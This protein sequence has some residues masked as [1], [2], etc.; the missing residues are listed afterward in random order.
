MFSDDYCLTREVLNGTKTITR[1]LLKLPKTCNGKEVY[2]FSVCTNDIGIQW[3]NL[4]DRNDIIVGNWKPKYEVG[5]IVAIAQPYKDIVA[6]LPMYSGIIL[7]KNG[8][9]Y[10]EFK[11]GWNN[12]MF[13]ET[14][15]MPHHIRITNVKIEHL[16]DISD[17]DILREGVR[18]VYDSH[19]HY[20]VYKY[21]S[22]G[23]IFYNLRDA[24]ASLFDKVY[25]ENTWKSNPWIVTYEFKL[26]D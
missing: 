15:L 13:V 19:S 11:Q 18:K 16:Q 3:V 6:D 2:G 26:V 14:D 22:D 21:L 25:D 12:K 9:P 4:L 1:R 10:N 7:D 5:E 17:Y 24:F 8:I 20:Y 23:K